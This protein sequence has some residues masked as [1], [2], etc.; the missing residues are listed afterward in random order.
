MIREEVEKL[1]ALGALPSEDM[2]EEGQLER[3]E[4][5]FDAIRPPIAA[6]EAERL[7]GLFGQDDCYGLAWTLLH[8]IE[9][10]PG[11]PIDSCLEKYEGEWIERLKLRVREKRDRI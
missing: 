10:A 11:W 3:Y 9:S 8:L 5:A 2:A 4:R 7:C 6:E 1:I